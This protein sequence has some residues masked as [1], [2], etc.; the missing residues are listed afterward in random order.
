[1]LEM[2][3]TSVNDY[4]STVNNERISL[5]RSFI[6]SPIQLLVRWWTIVQKAL[7]ILCRKEM[8][9]AGKETADNMKNMKFVL[10]VVE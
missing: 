6:E 4:H 8:M 9:V 1:M 3:W 10:Y 5:F 7:K 2:K